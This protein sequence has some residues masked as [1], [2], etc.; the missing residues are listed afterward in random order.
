MMRRCARC[1]RERDEVYFRQIGWRLDR[2]TPM[3]GSYCTFCSREMD[4]IRRADSEY[5]AVRRIKRK[6]RYQETRK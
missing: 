2:V 5:A 4:A 3:W 6:Q 1:H